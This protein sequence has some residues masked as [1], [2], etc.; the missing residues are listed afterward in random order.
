ML[1]R[2]LLVV[3]TFLGVSVV[4]CRAEINPR[5][6]AD[7]IIQA[8]M[9]R[10]PE[11]WSLGDEKRPKWTY[12]Q[13]LE[14]K[15]MMGW[16]HILGK[17]DVLLRYAD[18]YADQL[19]QEGFIQTYKQADYK[20][21]DLNAGKL[22]FQLYDA[23]GKQKYRAALDT[24]HQ[25]LK[26]QPRVGEGG[27]WHK[28]IYPHQM[29][30]DGLYMEAPFYAEYAMRYEDG[31][32]RDS[33]I[34]DVVRQF[35]VCYKHTWCDACHLLHHAWDES[36]SMN[37]A[38]TITGRSAHAWGRAEGWYL[39]A[40]V[41]VIGLLQNDNG[42]KSGSAQFSLQIGKLRSQLTSLCSTL[43]LL[44]RPSGCWLQ[45]LDCPDKQGNYEEM[46]ATAMIAYAFLKGYRLGILDRRFLLAGKRAV[47]GMHI[48][49]GEDGL[50]TLHDICR[51][52]GLSKDRDGSFEYYI[53][54][55]IVDNDPK[56]VGPL[57]FAL[58][59]YPATDYT[60]QSG[61]V[62]DLLHAIRMANVQNGNA[63]INIPNGVYDLQDR[64]LTS[65]MGDHILVVGEGMEATI[66]R[67]KPDI[68]DEGISTTATILNVGKGNVFKNL[69]LENALD[70]YNSGF[71]GRAVALQDKGDSTL[72]ER[73]RLL[74]HQD[75]YFSNN[76][77][78]VRWF[79]DCEI[80]GTVDF[81]C[82][83][84]DVF[85]DRC[86]LVAKYRKADGS[87]NCT[88]TAPK[89]R[90]GGRGFVFRNCTIRTDGSRFNLGRAWDNS[91]RCVYINTI[92]EQPEKLLSERFSKKGMKVCKADFLEYNTMDKEGRII[93]PQSHVLTITQGEQSDTRERIMTDFPAEDMNP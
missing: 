78:S 13:G 24:L 72:C 42:K 51:V 86:L 27:F 33:S 47:E 82:G 15:A 7:R 89:T 36:H 10:H 62:H 54:E 20:L 81:I 9:V 57:L 88:L 66:I 4:T 71:A 76:A 55:A 21:D 58:L 28:R 32:Q 61:N 90:E 45:V 64:V 93:S 83:D 31:A 53:G 77:T 43:L 26:T 80:H 46:S 41:D 73:V 75:T 92:L 40:L 29:W 59:E 65:L 8:E 17:E 68:K 48:G 38:D 1:T 63:V 37:W 44:Q 5:D 35:E 2:C 22:L 69:T 91:P 70:Y 12:T 11:S 60:V 39:M 18:A 19:V 52:A 6:L 14:L 16:R 3:L 79:R 25:Q 67:N 74:S 85:F 84:G 30:L 49:V 50:Q 56:G 23:T 87:G 34:A